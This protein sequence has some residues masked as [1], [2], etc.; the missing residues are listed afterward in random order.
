M[1]NADQTNAE[2]GPESSRPR[3]IG[4][5][6]DPETRCAHY[7]SPL[8]IVAIRMRC[9][10]EFY[11]CKDCH[12]ALASHAIQVWPRA[13]WTEKAILG[14]ACNA[15]LS[16]EAYVSGE[17]RCPA[18]GAAFNPGCRNHLRFYFEPTG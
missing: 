4:V 11:A 10:G 16:I 2:A 17:S 7:H 18:C 1:E 15:Q 14:G 5:D 9:C 12:D 8:D 13:E 6:V 3:V